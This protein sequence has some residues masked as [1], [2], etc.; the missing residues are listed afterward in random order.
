MYLW[1]AW[2]SETIYFCIRVLGLNVCATASTNNALL[3]LGC[4]SVNR[5]GL[6]WSQ[7]VPTPY[8]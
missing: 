2:N 1:L 3:I 6:F 8:L 5:V 4:C 7:A